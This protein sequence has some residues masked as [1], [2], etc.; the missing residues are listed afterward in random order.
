MRKKLVFL[1]LT[2]VLVLTIVGIGKFGA[3]SNKKNNNS[4]TVKKVE[5]KKKDSKTNKEDKKESQEKLEETYIG[6]DSIEESNVDSNNNNANNDSKKSEDTSIQSNHSTIDEKK[7]QANE[8]TSNNKNDSNKVDTTN[9]S[10][11][12]HKGII[13]CNDYSK[14][15]DIS[16]PIQFTYKKSIANTFYVEVKS[17]NGSVLGYFIEYVFKEN[18]YSSLEECNDIGNKIKSTLSDRVSGYTC[19]TEGILKINT[20]Y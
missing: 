9:P 2:I 12:I 6:K 10:Y 16:L 13:D 5:V 3:T 1:I 20:K 15:L 8:V 4:L 18:T 14:C 17:I 19:S 7:S 11:S